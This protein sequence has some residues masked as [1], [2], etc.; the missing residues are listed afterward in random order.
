MGQMRW[1][2]YPPE[3]VSSASASSA[4]RRRSSFRTRCPD[5]IRAIRCFGSDP[6]TPDTQL[7]GAS[8][9]NLQT[10]RIPK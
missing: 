3:A 10:F 1:S 5:R 9:E 8:T 2:L 7:S 6:A 4:F